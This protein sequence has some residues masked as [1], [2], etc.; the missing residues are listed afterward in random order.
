MSIVQQTDLFGETVLMGGTTAERVEYILENH[1]DARNDYR[2]LMF[3][4]WNTFDGLTEDVLAGGL[5]AFKRFLVD[6]ATAP[7]TLQNRAMEIQRRRPELD[8]VNEV[9]EWRDKQATAGPVGIGSG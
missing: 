1:Q 8:A 6:Q 7:K 5:P 4:Y 9:R 3:H 2:A